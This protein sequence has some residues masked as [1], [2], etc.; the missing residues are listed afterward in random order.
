MKR[1]C[2]HYLLLLFCLLPRIYFVGGVII[3]LD[4]PRENESQR[5]VQVINNSGRRI[6]VYWVNDLDSSKPVE[7]V[8]QSDDG[9]GYA[10]G[11]ETGLQTYVGHTFEIQEMPGKKSKVCTNNNDACW[12]RRFQVNS[13]EGQVVTINPFILLE[14]QASYEL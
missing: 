4:R 10:Y 6:N 14:M 9:D 1:C 5:S 7:L 3:G 13:E 2:Y 12:K 11:A 8:S